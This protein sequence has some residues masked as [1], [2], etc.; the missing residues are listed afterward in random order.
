MLSF[1]IP[2]P[3]K[4]PTSGTDAALRAV[5]KA[6][7][8]V[9]STRTVCTDLLAV[10]D[11]AFLQLSATVKHL[12]PQLQDHPEVTWDA[13][14]AAPMSYTVPVLRAAC[15]ELELDVKGTK[16]VL[17]QAL[18]QHFYVTAPSFATA[19][20]LLVTAYWRRTFAYATSMDS[21]SED[22]SD[23]NDEGDF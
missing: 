13:L 22:E 1:L 23:T 10:S 12:E 5:L 9:A 6:A 14:I 15:D 7:K 21:T 2:S 20:V 19:D 4:L 16:A 18:A 17:A 8:Q 3:A 11:A